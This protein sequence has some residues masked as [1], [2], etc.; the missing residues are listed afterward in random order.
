M[1]FQTCPVRFSQSLFLPF[2]GGGGG[3]GGVFIAAELPEQ[4]IP[5]PSLPLKGREFSSSAILLQNNF[6][7]TIRNPKSA[8]RNPKSEIRN[9]VTSPSHQWTM[10]FASCRKRARRGCR[11]HKGHKSAGT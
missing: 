4:P 8:I 3:G 10:A 11:S 6:H 1:R 2:Q 9:L 7:S 5:T